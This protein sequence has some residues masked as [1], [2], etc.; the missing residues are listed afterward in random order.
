LAKNLSLEKMLRFEGYINDE[1]LPLYYK[2]SD[3]FI[4]PT[5]ELE[6][7]GL[8]SIEAMACGIPVLATP[9]SANIEVIGNFDKTLLFDGIEP[10]DIANGIISFIKRND[11]EQLGKK[12]R[13]YVKFNFCWDKYIEKMENIYYELSNM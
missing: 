8:V 9:I 4:L 10:K 13:D 7:F 1:K 11:L 6:G 5:K 2:A 12:A 3:A